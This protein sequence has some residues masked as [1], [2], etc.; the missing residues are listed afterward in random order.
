MSSRGWE[1]VLVGVHVRIKLICKHDNV[2]V[3]ACSRYICECL[4]VLINVWGMNLYLS[5]EW[6]NYTIMSTNCTTFNYIEYYSIFHV[7]VAYCWYFMLCCLD[8]M[9]VSL[10]VY[11]L[12][13]HKL[14]IWDFT[15]F[16]TYFDPLKNTPPLLAMLIML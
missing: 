13:L 2:T 16:C 15:K 7:G 3:Y 11:R 9:L 1:R 4:Y 5:C 8:L 10:V 6:I 14:S 12:K